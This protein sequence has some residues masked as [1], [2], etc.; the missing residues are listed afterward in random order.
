MKIIHAGFSTFT[1]KWI[2]LGNGTHNY[3]RSKCSVHYSGRYQSWCSD[4]RELQIV[5]KDTVTLESLWGFCCI[6]ATFWH[7]SPFKSSSSL[8]VRFLCPVFSNLES[9]TWISIDWLFYFLSENACVLS[10][11]W[12][13]V[14]CWYSGWKPRAPGQCLERDSALVSRDLWH[15]Q[16]D[17]P[18]PIKWSY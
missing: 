7:M 4:L 8:F 1:V 11:T 16:A 3:R 2:I 14:E 17:V 9:H 18:D 6:C 10:S 12:H 13:W 5:R 15:G